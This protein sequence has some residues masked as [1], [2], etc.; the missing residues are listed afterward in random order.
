MAFI[1]SL[2]ARF[3]SNSTIQEFHKYSTERTKGELQSEGNGETGVKTAGAIE[4]VKGL[5]RL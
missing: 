3:S 1:P 5:Q 4:R 2:E